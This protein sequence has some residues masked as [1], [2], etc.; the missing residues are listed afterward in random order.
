MK[1]CIAPG[2][3]TGVI[4]ITSSKSQA[5]RRIIC[6][7][8][9]S[10]SSTIKLN[11]LSADI[12]ATISCLNSLG[13]KIEIEP[14]CI[15]VTPISK[16]EGEKQLYCGESGSTLRFL[17][18]IIGALGL[19]ATFF[20]EGKLPSRPIE[21]L[22]SLLEK[23]GM[24]FNKE[25]RSLTCRGKLSSGNY[26]I[27]GSVSSQYIS[28][29]LFA[30]PLLDGDSYIE[31][32]GELQSAAYIKMTEEELARS[33]IK[34]QKTA[35]GYFVPGN[36][37]YNCPGGVI[38]GDWSNAAFYLCMGAKSN[39]GV[40]VL[41]LKNDSA[42]GDKAI[43][44]I[45]RRFGAN[46]IESPSAVTVKKGQLSGI[47]VDA[48]GI[49]DLV[50]TICALA[51]SANGKTIITNAS[52][53]RFKESDRLASTLSLLLSIGA[54]AYETKDGLVINGKSSL[55]GGTV[56]AHN[57]HRIAMAAAVAASSAIYDIIVEGAECVSKSYPDFWNDLDSTEVEK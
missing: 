57:D 48:S 7:A 20:M 30:L 56:N 35:S 15:N 51:A 33:G 17:I 43:I 55:N 23:R 36:Q 47:I 54:D 10:S 22:T 13:S 44:D 28:G 34:F 18:P 39:N 19:E 27:T 46:V 16:R 12:S 25:D 32:E 9:S 4:T 8:L 6:A 2:S 1:K 38:E 40:S 50:P 49:P 3:R 29:L 37:K 45:L 31:I 26:K 53:L 14:N 24:S 21:S 41:G 42:Q 52:R 11:G 5:H